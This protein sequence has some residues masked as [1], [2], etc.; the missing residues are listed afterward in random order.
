LQVCC[1]AIPFRGCRTM[2]PCVPQPTPIYRLRHVDRLKSSVARGG[3]FAPPLRLAMSST[4][5]QVCTAGVNAKRGSSCL[6]RWRQAGA[7]SRERVGS[8]CDPI[9]GANRGPTGPQ[10]TARPS[11]HQYRLPLMTHFSGTTSN[12]RH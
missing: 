2:P 12:E 4:R 1:T 10:A 8:A 3:M 5:S 7:G 11:Y 6:G 9:L